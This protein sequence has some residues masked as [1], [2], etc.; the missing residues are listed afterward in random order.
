VGNGV[1][2]PEERRG[3]NA[4]WRKNQGTPHHPEHKKIGYDNNKFS[5]NVLGRQGRFGES[6]VE[7]SGQDVGSLRY[8]SWESVRTFGGSATRTLSPSVK[9]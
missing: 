9:V 7:L 5:T 1:F 8:A 3:T 2:V 4:I 6:D